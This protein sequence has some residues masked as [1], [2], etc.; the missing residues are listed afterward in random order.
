MANGDP[1]IEYENALALVYDA[2]ALTLKGLRANPDKQEE[3]K[4]IKRLARLKVEEAD[5]IAMID[6]LEDEPAENLPAPDP[7]LV[8]EIARLSGE[9]EAATKR[10]LSAAG[11]LAAAGKVLDL[12]IKLT[13]D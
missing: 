6:A 10:N 7:A 9:V 1:I 12:A 2:Q 8:A 13:G 11:A 5:L 3:R 4:L